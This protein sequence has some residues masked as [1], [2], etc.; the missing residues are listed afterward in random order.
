M[1]GIAG[2]FGAEAEPRTAW[3]TR[4]LEHRGP[5]D[6]GVWASKRYPVA[7][8][9]R[10]LKILDLS[11]LGHQPM[12]TPDGRWTLTFNGEIYNFVELRGQLQ[13]AGHVFR[14]HTDT[15]VLLGAPVEWGTRALDLIRGMYAFALW[16]DKEGRLLLVRD[17]LGI[18]PLYYAIRG[19]SLC[20]GS[21]IKAVLASG[22]VEPRL[23]PRALESYLRLLW[24]PEPR[25]L[26]AGVEKLEPG[27]HL[28]WDGSR[29]LLTRFWDV[30][31]PSEPGGQSDAGVAETLFGTL[32]QAVSRQLRADVPVGAFLSG[33]LDSTAILNLAVAAGV[34]EIRSYSIGFRAED[35]T[36]EGA[37]DDVRFA[38]IAANA[39][40]VPHEEIV[41]SPDVVNLLPKMVSH[42]EDP[43]ADPAAL[44]C[45]VICEAARA[46]STVL[47]S[48]TGGDELFG[49]YRKYLSG[50]FGAH[51]QR[52]PARVRHAILEPLARRLP[53]SVGG[54]GIRHFRLA[55]KLMEYA[56]APQRDR[57][58]GY[59]TYYDAG[60]LEE[61]L[62]GDPERVKDPYLGLTPLLQAWDRRATDDPID[63][64]TY[65]D[66]KYYLPGL[67]LAYM[68]KASMAASVEVRV[69]LLD[70][71]VLDFAARLPGR[72]KVDGFRT[73]VILRESMKGIVPEA[74]LRRPKAPFSA[75]V[76]SW[77]NRE[78]SPMVSEYLSPGHVLKRG[79]LN[80]GTVYRLLREHRLG[81]E[82]HSLRIWALLTLEIWLQEFY[83]NRARFNMP[84]LGPPV[85]LVNV[86]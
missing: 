68:D 82:D 41:L 39:A 26:F 13:A 4:L 75:P 31:I 54:V 38:K 48:G 2:Y 65:V 23:D 86:Q 43:V 49:G 59:S 28:H 77:L 14:S 12:T 60:E 33:G 34:R 22:L 61:L 19:T 83:D 52:I 46:S 18:K 79:L 72:F 85:E 36:Q 73:K 66:L 15:E 84:V 50:W 64:M 20:F 81:L 30:P 9:N 11:P 69:P 74:I 45:Y 16:D 35:R 44:N 40:G 76:R 37:I 58:L 56:G 24:V 51:Y 62:G 55:K 7:L 25:T 5:D 42:L 32:K 70:D 63:R 71:D 27:T 29:A 3:M 10:R 8:G 47:L 6:E 57:F 1:C 53:V 67:G 80:P 78:L 17:R 21:E